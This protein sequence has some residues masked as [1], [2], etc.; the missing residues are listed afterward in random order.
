MVQTKDSSYCNS[1]IG[2]GERENTGI[3]R[4]FS[5]LNSLGTAHI[6]MLLGAHVF[7]KGVGT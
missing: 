4:P 7:P 2:S 1:I 6:S 3:R 5:S